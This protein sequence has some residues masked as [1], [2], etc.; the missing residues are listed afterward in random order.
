MPAEH[1]EFLVEEPSM[2]IFLMAILPRLIE[3]RA[4]FAVHSYQG[5]GDLLSKLGARLRGYAK[6][7]PDNYKIFVLVDR[8]SADCHALKQTLEQQAAQAN[9]VSR[10]MGGDW[11]FVSRIA[12]EELEAWYFGNWGSVSACY[13]KV[14]TNIPNQAAYREPDNIGGGT[15][16]ALERILQR[17]HYFPGGLR[18]LEIAANVGAHFDCDN[19]S[20]PSFTAFRQA[21]LEA[22]SSSERA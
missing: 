9:L 1:L 17:N 19:C 21:V 11:N 15:W 22:V 16:E 4:T 10:S 12:I 7:I 2:E 18:K 3:G 20:S 6:W 13:P 14:S 8:D 5:K